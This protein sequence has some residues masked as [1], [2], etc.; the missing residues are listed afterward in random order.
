MT[1][2]FDIDACCN[3][4]IFQYL[5]ID[6]VLDSLF[7]ARSLCEYFWLRSVFAASIDSRISTSPSLNDTAIDTMRA[8]FCSL[9]GILPR[10]SARIMTCL[11]SA[12]VTEV[13]NKW[14]PSPFCTRY[15]LDNL[16]FN[17][18]ASHRKSALE[19]LIAR[20]SHVSADDWARKQLVSHIA[21]AF[22]G[23]DASYV[24]MLHQYDMFAYYMVTTDEANYRDARGL[25]F[26]GKMLMR[27]RNATSLRHARVFDKCHDI[28]SNVDGKGH[29]AEQLFADNCIRMTPWA[30]YRTLRVIVTHDL[31]ALLTIDGKCTVIERILKLIDYYNMANDLSHVAVFTDIFAVPI[32]E[33]TVFPEIWD[34]AMM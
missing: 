6:N 5:S 28:F 32:D 25:N 31:S 12:Y 3:G 16:E 15:M 29:N 2:H 23:S 18:K 22:V 26:V 9:F 30:V 21:H 17:M 10:N 20:P 14:A 27:G 33:D 13:R 19:Y 24:Q 7:Q 8:D 1:C 4:T 34:T 11:T